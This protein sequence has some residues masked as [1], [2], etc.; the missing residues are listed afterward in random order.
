MNMLLIDGAPSTGKSNS[1]LICTHMCS[2]SSRGKLNEIG[3]MGNEKPTLW[4]L[5]KSEKQFHFS[6]KRL[7]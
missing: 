3:L 7:A 6:E 4:M 2:L 1:V 5:Q